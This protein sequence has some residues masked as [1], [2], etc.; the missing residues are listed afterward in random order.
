MQ[1]F[2]A[3]SS[4]VAERDLFMMVSSLEHHGHIYGRI[5]PTPLVQRIEYQE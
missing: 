3:L 1:S 2:K 4:Q 5:A